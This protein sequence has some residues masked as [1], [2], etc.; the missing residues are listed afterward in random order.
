MLLKV[1]S[2]LDLVLKK[3]DTQEEV[4]SELSE[5]LFNKKAPWGSL[6]VKGREM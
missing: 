5:F 3:L 6:M 2:K 1:D 4:L